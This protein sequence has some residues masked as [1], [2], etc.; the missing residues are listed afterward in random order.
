MS[1]CRLDE[2]GDRA[3]HE[4]DVLVLELLD[5][6][7]VSLLRGV[8]AGVPEA[9]GDAGDGDAGEQEQRCVGVAQS[10]HGDDGHVGSLAMAF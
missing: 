1:G 9:L 5:D 10:M 7:Q 8:H 6:V 4:V 3:H 2:A